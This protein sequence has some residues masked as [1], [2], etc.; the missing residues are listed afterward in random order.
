MRRREVTQASSLPSVLLRAEG[1]IP[2]S[3]EPPTPDW[4]TGLT[5][6]RLPGSAPPRP[7]QDILSSRW[8]P[9]TGVAFDRHA[10]VKTLTAA[11]ASLDAR[12]AA[13]ETRLT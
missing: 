7:Y 1:N 13:M 3:R 10:A 6:Q 5:R 11:V 4:S 9:A 8:V 12:M 2:G